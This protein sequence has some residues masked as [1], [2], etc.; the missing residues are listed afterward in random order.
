MSRYIAT[1]LSELSVVISEKAILEVANLVIRFE[2]RGEHPQAFNGPTLGVHPM[3]F[4]VPSDRDALFNIFGITELQL[5]NIVKTI[6][7]V[8]MSRKVTSDVFNIFCIWL[9]HM[10]YVYVR[11]KEVREKFQ[12][13]V[14]KYLHYRYFTS[15]VNHS[16]PHGANSGVMSAV[17]NSLTNRFDI[18]KHGTWKKTIEERCKD[19]LSKSSIH[20]TVLETGQDD[21]AFLYAISDTQSRMRDKVKEIAT[22][23]YN[24]HASG[25]SIG[26]TSLVSEVDGKK[27]IASPRAVVDSVVMSV[28]TEVANIREFIDDAYMTSVTK[29]FTAVQLTYYAPHYHIFPVC[30]T[31]KFVRESLILSHVYRTTIARYISAL[32]C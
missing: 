16:F 25:I 2:L 12:L 26:H 3:R 31:C 8:D 10:S 6:Q 32:V 29:E 21:K 23:Y 20:R 9:I 27:L 28:V 13:D 18:V 5:V 7:S 1:A 17:I 15:L 4:D 11:S 30:Q 22:V 19:L 24:Q 14:M